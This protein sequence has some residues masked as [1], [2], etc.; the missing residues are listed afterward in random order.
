VVEDDAATGMQPAE[1][2]GSEGD[3]PDAVG[4]LFEPDELAAE[5]VADIDPGGVPSDA[6]IGRDFSDLEVGGVVGRLGLGRHGPL[7][8][9]VD[10][11]RR[12]LVV[13]LVRSDLVEVGA[14]GV[15]AAL[16]GAAIAGW[17]DRRLG[18]EIPVHALVSAVLMGRGRLDE[19]GHD[20]EL[21]PPDTE[22]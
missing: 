20:A 4:Y 17:R 11:S 12:P 5:Q 1:R 10:G 7:R 21:D 2:D 3:R 6:A 16:L 8:R 18:L 14:K 19:V 22:A 13:G 9:L 15:E